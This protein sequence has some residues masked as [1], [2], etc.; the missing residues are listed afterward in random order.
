MPVQTLN[1]ALCQVYH[2]IVEASAN[3]C[4][5]ACQESDVDYLS[6]ASQSATGPT[7]FA[8]LPLWGHRQACQEAAQKW[9]TELNP[10]W[11]R[12]TKSTLTA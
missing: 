7:S 4:Q 5:A 8:Q 6:H 10:N 12:G 2:L 3:I 1:I 9:S 11:G